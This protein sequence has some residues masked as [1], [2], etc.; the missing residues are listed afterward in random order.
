MH[1]LLFKMSVLKTLVLIILCC[2]F[3]K[4]CFDSFNKYLDPPTAF[5]ISNED[6]YDVNWPFISALRMPLVGETG[7]DETV[8]SFMKMMDLRPNISFV[9][10]EKSYFTK[11]Q[12]Q[13]NLTQTRF[14]GA[15]S[16]YKNWFYLQRHLKYTVKPRFNE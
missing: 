6:A 1:H 9:S 8:Q 4:T 14:V 5:V 16:R 2:I 13:Q 12:I 11:Q 3:A 15:I 7:D 10:Q